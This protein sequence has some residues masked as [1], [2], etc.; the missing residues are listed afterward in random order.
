MNLRHA[1]PTAEI[2]H[3]GR[4]LARDQ[5]GAFKLP[6]ST[7]ERNAINPDYEE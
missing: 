4:D 7:G 1:S 3:K 2:A 5:Q 6:T